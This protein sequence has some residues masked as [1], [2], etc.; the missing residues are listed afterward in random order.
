[1]S[2]GQARGAASVPS[3]PQQPYRY[4]APA[5]QGGRQ[6]IHEPV[7]SAGSGGR[8]V[9][10]VLAVVLALLVLLCAG[11]I[12]FW[13]KQQNYSQGVGAQITVTRAGAAGDQS[14]VTS[15]RLFQEARHGGSLTWSVNGS[16]QSYSLKTEGRRTL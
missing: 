1:V 3:G 11:V 7:R 2:G 5:Q 9:L 8:Q 10:V 4:P 12:S 16:G 13:L 14:P 15:Y 6:P